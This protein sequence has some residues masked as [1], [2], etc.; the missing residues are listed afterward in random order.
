[1]SSTKHPPE[2]HAFTEKQL[3][4]LK[5]VSEAAPSKLNHFRK[6]Y[7]QKSLRSAITAKCLEC[8]NFGAAEVRLC[9]GTACPLYAV[10]PYQAS[11]PHRNA[12]KT[13]TPRAMAEENNGEARRI[14]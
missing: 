7:A 11:R 9:S 8:V 14:R 5:E 10:R 2:G 4:M 6:A 3:N 13:N 12:E 1:M